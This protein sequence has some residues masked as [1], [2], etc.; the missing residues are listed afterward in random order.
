[1]A[2]RCQLLSLVLVLLA[3]AIGAHAQAQVQSPLGPGAPPMELP[4]GVSNPAE[5]T[6]YLAALNTADA[7]KR[8]QALEIF[9]A[10]YPNSVLRTG[11]Y[12]QAMA[13]WQTAGDPAKADALAVR[14]LQLDPDNVRAL[15]NRA[16]VGR[17][18][19]TAGAADG[20]ATA[21]AAAQQGMA[22][23]P[24]WQR[25]AALSEPDF[26][27]LKLQF[28]AIFDG[29]LGFA[30]L[31][32]KDYGKARSHLLE[33][34]TIEPDTMPDIYQLSVA[35]L[36]G[37]PLDALGF[38][39]AARAI[40]VSRKAKNEPAAAS[41]EKYARSRY[42]HYHG[43]EQGWADL[44]ARVAAGSNRPPGNFA[45]SI[46]RALTPSESAVQMASGESGNLSFVE[47][48]FVL[49]HRDDSPD[50]RTAA[51]KVWK[52]I[53]EK[54][55]GGA[56]LKIPMKVVSAT[57]DRLQG[58]ISEENQASN[59]VDLDVELDHSLS[60]LPA[61]GSEIAVVGSL[62]NYRSQP[63]LFYLTKAELADESL[64]VAGGVCADPRPQ[65]CTLEYRAACGTRRD[66]SRKTYGN[67]CSA[68][69]D[70][71]VVSQGAGACP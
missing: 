50:N 45:A 2:A 66:G 25:P 35:M 23:L 6:S 5:Y 29:T 22:A 7:T 53:G 36:E 52:A 48:G 64:P 15:V 59:T 17:A 14:L 46:S 41:I 9:V 57:P 69:A 43:S 37:Q 20:L 10:W 56:R 13:A 63:F 3:A 18:R 28:V 39:Y 1:M 11:A 68:C 60:P 55:K 33:A 70:S 38:W 21:V 40:A 31:Q 12:E 4:R 62:G 19:A 16:Y 71:E 49:S 44:L 26:T 47:W 27:R 34:V 30:A 51:D 8:A 58:A 24:K 54:Q 65:M 61:V 42:H 67:A 32:A